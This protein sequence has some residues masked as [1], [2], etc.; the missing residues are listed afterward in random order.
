V[1][2]SPSQSETSCISIRASSGGLATLPRVLRAKQEGR[3]MPYGRALQCWL[4][5]EDGNGSGSVGL[6]LLGSL[7]TRT[8]S[9]TWDFSPRAPNA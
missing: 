9:L 2:L 1:F 4:G 6:P 8:P 5:E 3:E 7:L